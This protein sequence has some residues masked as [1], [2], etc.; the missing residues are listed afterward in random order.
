[1]PALTIPR[2]LAPTLLVSC[3]HISRWLQCTQGGFSVDQGFAA[4]WQTSDN[5]L[6]ISGSKTLLSE[7]SS[8][9]VRYC[10]P[11]GGRLPDH[12]NLRAGKRQMW[13]LCVNDRS[14]RGRRT[15]LGTRRR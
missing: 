4:E 5:Y 11:R 7:L 12:G 8:T 9:T 10:K 14:Q 2:L 6:G 13:D 1:M 3:H 15:F